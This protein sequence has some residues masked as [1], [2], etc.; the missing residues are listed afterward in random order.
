MQGC[1]DTRDG[2][3]VRRYACCKTV[4][5]ILTAPRMELLERYNPKNV[6]FANGA[7]WTQFG[8]REYIRDAMLKPED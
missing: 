3:A 1:N 5:V 2:S 8:L 7:G 6:T 4:S